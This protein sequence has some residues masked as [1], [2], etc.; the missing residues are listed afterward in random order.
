MVDVAA[1][2]MLESHGGVSSAATTSSDRVTPIV[3]VPLPSWLGD[4][5]F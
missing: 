1:T 2:E 4:A 3:H 5:G